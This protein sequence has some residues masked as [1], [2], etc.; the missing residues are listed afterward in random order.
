MTVRAAEAVLLY[1]DTDLPALANFVDAK[2]PTDDQIRC[3]LNEAFTSKESPTIIAFN[4][5]A[6]GVAHDLDPW[7]FG[8][9]SLV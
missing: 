6:V 4:P 1:D 3:A 2:I 7:R 5:Y 9:C 8:P